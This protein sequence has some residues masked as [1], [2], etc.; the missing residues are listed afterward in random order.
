MSSNT[1][2]TS[3]S[4]G[5]GVSAAVGNVQ[6]VRNQ[7]SIT[8]TVTLVGS[9]INNITINDIRTQLINENPLFNLDNMDQ[10]YIYAIRAYGVA[11]GYL[12]MAPYPHRQYTYN[13]IVS[14]TSSTS[15]YLYNSYQSGQDS[16][17]RPSGN[18]TQLYDI[19]IEGS[20]RPTLEWTYPKNRS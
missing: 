12:S 14:G 17:S 15:G 5:A 19:G 7:T 13:S 6:K 9:G 3:G 4:A 2:G 16:L 11:G 18:L 1:V 10:M 20:T 8:E